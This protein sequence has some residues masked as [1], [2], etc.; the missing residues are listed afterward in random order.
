MGVAVET[1]GLIFVAP[2]LGF[3][4][5][6]IRK[7]LHDTCQPA[8]VLDDVLVHQRR[9]LQ[10]IGQC[11]FA[12]LDSEHSAGDVLGCEETLRQ[13]R[14]PTVGEDSTQ[15]GEHR[16][17]LREAGIGSLCEFA[18]VPTD[19]GRQRGKSDAVGAR[20]LLDRTD[21]PQPVQRTDRTEDAGP[22]ADD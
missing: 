9:H 3:I 20:R 7:P 15:F 11:T 2:P 13:G 22:G 19:Q 4:G 14:E 21:H 5:D 6:A 12:V 18:C 1:S 17:Q 16:R 10:Q 8:L